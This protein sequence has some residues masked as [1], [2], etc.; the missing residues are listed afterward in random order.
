VFEKMLARNFFAQK[1]IDLERKA[2]E[3]EENKRQREKI[4]NRERKM[5]ILSEHRDTHEKSIERLVVKFER[6]R[7]N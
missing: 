2:R 1:W 4:K 5:M 7:I 3:G 6:L